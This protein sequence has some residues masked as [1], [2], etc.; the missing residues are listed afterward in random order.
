MNIRNES[1][2]RL[3]ARLFTG[4]L[5]GLAAAAAAHHGNPAAPAPAPWSHGSATSGLPGPAKPLGPGY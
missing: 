4:L 1:R 5:L 3:R 2:A